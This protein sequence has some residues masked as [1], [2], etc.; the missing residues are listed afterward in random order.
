MS[1]GQVDLVIGRLLSFLAGIGF[2]AAALAAFIW[3]VVL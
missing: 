3:L 2:V 1:A